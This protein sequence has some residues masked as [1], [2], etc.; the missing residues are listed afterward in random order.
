MSALA[1]I[2]ISDGVKV[3]GSDG[4]DSKTISRLVNAGADIKIGHAAEN[5]K[6]PDLVVY[7]AAISDDNPE[8]VEARARGI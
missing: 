5:I 1:H 6:N 4:S 7:T 8:L 2:L 3:S